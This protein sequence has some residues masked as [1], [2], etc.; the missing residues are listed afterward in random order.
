[1]EALLAGLP[2][3][4]RTLDEYPE[5]PDPVEDGETFAENAEKKAVFVAARTGLPALADDSG[6]EVDALDGRPGVHSARYAGDPDRETRDRANNEKLLRE[7]QGVPDGE[8]TARFRCCI[9]FAV[10]GENGTDVVARSDGKVEGVIL[11]GLRGD[12]G[13]GYDP[14]FFHQPS[15]CTFAELAAKRKNQLSHR[16]SALQEIRPFLEQW[17]SNRAD[18]GSGREPNT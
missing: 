10:P 12:E 11:E 4:V 3:E 2:V 16:A 5:V 8:R 15:N 7:L 17:F 13:F 18:G 1:M 14:L 6:L 9:A